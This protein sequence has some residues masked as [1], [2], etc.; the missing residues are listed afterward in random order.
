MEKFFCGK[1]AHVE[2]MAKFDEKSRFLWK[3]M[4]GY[5]RKCVREWPKN[6]VVWSQVR[7]VFQKATVG[8]SPV[9]QS[10]RQNEM[11]TLLARFIILLMPTKCSQI[12][13]V[14]YTIFLLA[15][16]TKKFARI[17]AGDVLLEITGPFS[18]FRVTR[19]CSSLGRERLRVR[20]TRAG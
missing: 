2:K 11:G 16:I 13:V 12:S 8:V 20:M 3:K 19:S 5:A 4:A 18:S 1:M 7:R 6:A 17:I 15:T 14:R 9:K 10:L